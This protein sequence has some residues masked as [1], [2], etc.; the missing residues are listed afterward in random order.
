MES[1]LLSL[2]PWGADVIAG[3]QTLRSGSLDAVMRLFTFLGD[4][5]SLIAA[6]VVLYWC[7]NKGLGLRLGALALLSNYVNSGVKYI[8]KIPRPAG[9]RVAILRPEDSPSFP[10]GHAQQSLAIGGYLGFLA[11]RAW[12]W[13]VVAALALLISISRIYLGVHFPQD[14]LGGWL[15]G[16]LLLAGYLWLGKWAPP[17]LRRW[18]PAAQLGL[19]TLGALALLFLHP[20]DL[21]GRYPAETAAMLCGG[22]W[23]FGVGAVL[24]PRH[25]RFACAG[26][27]WQRL[28]RLPVGLAA[29]GLV[30]LAGAY[31]PA[32]GS[33]IIVALL[34][35]VRYALV[36]FTA[37]YVAPWL[38]VR[39][40]LA[41]REKICGGAQ[42]MGRQC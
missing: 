6:V 12:V 15:I 27:P 42:A 31:L 10:S 36:A 21:Q 18:P 17:R 1:W 14:I 2:I 40:G 35:H 30:Y 37:I 8:Y 19:A 25:I 26:R 29:V 22:L 41:G 13:V 20:S 34:R 3:V 16:L 11:R 9:P 28:L 23:G 4:S 32:G 5:Y 7:V 33:Q 38:F 39:L 24:E